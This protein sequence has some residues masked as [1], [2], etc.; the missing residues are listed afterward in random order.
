MIIYIPN[1]FLIALVLFQTFA[2][3][4]ENYTHFVG[5]IFKGGEGSDTFAYIW[6]SGFIL[7]LTVMV[8]LDKS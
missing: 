5:K 8:I 2:K 7:R 3:N 4:N 6:L 1:I